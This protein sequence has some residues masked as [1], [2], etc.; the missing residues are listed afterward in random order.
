VRHRTR[1]ASWAGGGPRNG[2][3]LSAAPGHPAP[4]CASGSVG[5][6]RREATGSPAGCQASIPPRE[7]GDRGKAVLP[8]QLRGSDRAPLGGSHHNQRPP[9]VGDQVAAPAL[10]GRQGQHDGAVDVSQRAGPRL[11]AAHVADEGWG[12]LGPQRV[13]L[14]QGQPPWAAPV[15][16]EHGEEGHR[17]QQGQGQEPGAHQGRPSADGSCASRQRIIPAGAHAVQ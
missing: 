5:V 10:E 7:D 14:V 4:R 2:E 12:V 8:Y 16:A 3:G 15:A 13:S 6:L 17:R 11:R 9:A 1:H